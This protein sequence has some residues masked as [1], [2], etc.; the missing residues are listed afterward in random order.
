[1]GDIIKV[2]CNEKEQL[3]MSKTS[4]EKAKVFAEAKYATSW[5]Y[6]VIKVI[7]GEAR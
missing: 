3:E 7:C 2:S 6:D 5:I 1:M 4:E